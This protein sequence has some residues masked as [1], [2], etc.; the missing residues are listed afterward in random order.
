MTANITAD[1]IFTSSYDICVD[2]MGASFAMDEAFIF[3]SCF[4]SRFL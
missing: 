2:S 1:V 4:I 3:N